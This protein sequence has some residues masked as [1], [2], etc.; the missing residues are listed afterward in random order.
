MVSGFLTSPCDHWRMSS[1]VARPMRSSSKKL[2]S[3]KI[4]FFQISPPEILAERESPAGAPKTTAGRC[5]LD[6]FDAARLT[7][8][9]VDAQ[10]LGSTEDVLVG[11]AHLDGHAVAGEHL[12][13]EAQRLHLLDQHLE[14]L[15]DAGLRDVLALDDGLVDLHP[16]EHVVG[17]DGQ[18]LLQRV[19]GAVG[20]E[21]PDLHLAEPLAT[22]LRLA[23]QRLLGD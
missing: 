8:G 13:V 5:P 2:T 19:G 4:S 20:L 7:P 3:S 6:L 12:D 17:L 18:Q 11:L 16:A 9:Q 23:A 15:R 14:R 22:E 1:A 21:G 10:L